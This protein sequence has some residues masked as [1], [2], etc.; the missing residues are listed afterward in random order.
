MQTLVVNSC[1]IRL[2]NFKNTTTATVTHQNRGANNNA[3]TVYSNNAVARR[4]P[5]NNNLARNLLKTL[6]TDYRH[7]SANANANATSSTLATRETKKIN[8]TNLNAAASSSSRGTLNSKG[9]GD[10]FTQVWN[11][12]KHAGSKNT[13][14][15]R[16]TT[17]LISCLFSNL[18][19]LT[20]NALLR[21]KFTTATLP[22][23]TA[24]SS[25][26]L[27]STALLN[28]KS[29]LRL[30]TAYSGYPSDTSVYKTKLL[31]TKSK[32]KFGDDAWFIAKQKFVD[33]LG[34]ADGVGGWH[35]IGIDPSKFSSNLMKT[36]KRYVEQEFNNLSKNNTNLN[37]N[38]A[39]PIKILKQSYQALIESK[40]NRLLI[41]SS[42]ACIILFHHDTN[43]LHTANL[44]DSGFVVIRDNKVIHKSQEQ[45]HYFN[46][47]YQM[48][49]LPGP[50]SP[51]ISTT[52]Q[53]QQSVLLNQ[54]Q[55]PTAEAAATQ[56][57]NNEDLINDSPDNAST[58]S[59]QLD[60]G[61]FIVVATDGLWD[62]L[63]EKQLLVEI[64]NIKSFLLDDL[65]KAANNIAR[66]A[67]ELAFDPD[68]QSPFALAARQ[69]GI[70]INGGKPDDVTVL[71]A[72]VS[73]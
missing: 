48:G 70:N 15:I 12:T 67:I 25:N 68:Y 39:T 17:G 41:G 19:F 33:V 10:Q 23:P 50:S 29:P 2:H 3:V 46:S 56:N 49:I 6:L 22:P 26:I 65:E 8:S 38:S 30:I 62:N 61:D 40:Q 71:L 32:I 7:N 47:P 51:S 53:Q 44:G 16:T 72:R 1:S 31:N 21:S 34:V 4:T 18:R 36:C 69:N 9:L 27:L 58:S 64:S 43:L 66:K 20:I 63:T 52:Q 42:T 35:S 57:E 37:V 45:Q 60:E 54:A 24:S 5:N 28:A 59:I 14:A 73:K 11:R 55:Q 13:N